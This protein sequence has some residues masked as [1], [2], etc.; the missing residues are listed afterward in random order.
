MVKLTKRIQKINPSPTLALTSKAK[1]MQAQ[2]IDVVSFAAGEPDFDTPDNIKQAAIQAI[3]EGFTKYTDVGGIFELKD[4]IIHKLKRDNNLDYSRDQ[5]L[6]SN[7]GKHALYN[8]A[9]V[10]FEDGDEVIIPAPYWVSYPDQVLVNDAKPVIVQTTDKTNFKITPEQLQKAITKKTRAFILNSPSNPTGS[11]YDPEELKE[12]AGILVE[13][14]IICIADEIYDQIVFDGFKQES[15]AA[16]SEPMKALT[17]VVNGASKVYAMTGWRMGFTAGPADIIKAMNKLQGQVTSNI[18]SI[19]QRACV[20]AY[21]GPQHE[22]KKMVLE[23]QKRRDVIAS[24]LNA[25][26]GIT[27]Y[28]PQGAFYVFPNVLDLLGKKTK[29]G[30]FLKTSADFCMHLLEQENVVTVPGED[31]GTPGYLRLSY[32]TSQFVINKGL[33][34]IKKFVGELR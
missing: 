9:Q 28:K 19:T 14:K 2:G 29:N 6:V 3:R 22:I 10:L 32:A 24:A 12:L 34:R 17:L 7:G 15:M 26:K 21:T 31:F 25:M 4:A 30:H 23:F 5:I 13:K 8:I 16:I 27:C 33:E 20:E 1:A 11:A 18:C